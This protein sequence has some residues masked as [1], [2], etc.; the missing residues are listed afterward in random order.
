MKISY[1]LKN[2]PAITR[3][4]IQQSSPNKALFYIDKGDLVTFK[5]SY[6]DSFDFASKVLK[7]ENLKTV[8]KVQ[9]NT[10]NIEMTNIQIEDQPYFYEVVTSN[11]TFLKA[12]DI[13]LSSEFD[14]KE[15]NGKVYTNTV[16]TNYEISD[17]VFIHSSPV[18]HPSNINV[19]FYDRYI[20]LSV[21]KAS[22]NDVYFARPST[23]TVAEARR[24]NDS[25]IEI[26]SFYLETRS[27]IIR[28]IEGDVVLHA[29]TELLPV[30][31]NKI[32]PKDKLHSIDSSLYYC[33]GSNNLYA[34]SA[35]F[36]R[37]EVFVNYTAKFSSH[38]FEIENE[39]Y[40][41]IENGFLVKS[42][43]TDY[44]IKIKKEIDLSQI[45]FHSNNHL[46]KNRFEIKASN[47]GLDFNGGLHDNFKRSLTN[48]FRPST[49]LNPSKQVYI[50]TDSKTIYQ[51]NYNSFEVSKV[52]KD[53]ILDLMDDD[54]S[55][56]IPPLE[57]RD[58]VVLKNINKAYYE[59]DK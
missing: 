50:S 27:S 48:Y 47:Y 51:E 40:F 45:S 8:F 19:K 44:D 30:E 28:V 1:T 17:G 20:L 4:V 21:T 26:P 22:K 49:I 56:N 9:A 55:F 34:E 52:S 15:L 57:S 10:T 18:V 14:V 54:Y 24:V 12:Q 2:K 53:S 3:S 16:I 32:S 29:K 23:D 39:L 6:N 35:Y 13:L 59:V 33:S 11:S 58:K 42:S 31:Y 46:Y 25:K 7:T 5:T 41:K 43:S 38:I 36:T 37:E